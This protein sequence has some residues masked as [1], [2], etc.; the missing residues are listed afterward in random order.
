MRRGA[1]P[2]RGLREAQFKRRL[3]DDA[4]RGVEW[5]FARGADADL[6][7]KQPVL[8]SWRWSTPTIQISIRAGSALNHRHATRTTAPYPRG[9]EPRRTADSVL[10]AVRHA[11]NVGAEPTAA[12]EVV[13]DAGHRDIE[14]GHIQAVIA[15]AQG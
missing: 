3:V 4:L 15:T 7:V 12:F 2:S 11:A 5:N 6:H 9:G 10:D 14:A 8:G 1:S 13:D